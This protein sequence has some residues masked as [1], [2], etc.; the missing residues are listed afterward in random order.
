MTFIYNCNSCGSKL[1]QQFGGI[2]IIS[3]RVQK[4]CSAM[5]I[6]QWKNLLV[7]ITAIFILYKSSYLR[8]ILL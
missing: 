7:H 6:L 1:S 5:Q 2:I 3:G 8:Q 4:I